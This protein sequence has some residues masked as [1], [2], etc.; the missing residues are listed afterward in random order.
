M[1]S[2]SIGYKTWNPEMLLKAVVSWRVISPT[3]IDL[4]TTVFT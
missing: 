4:L 2:T 3:S 1:T